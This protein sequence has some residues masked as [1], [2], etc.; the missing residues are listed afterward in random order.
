LHIGQLVFRNSVRAPLRTFMT[1]LTVAIML[2]AFVFP[3]T[4]V[5]EQDRYVEEAKNDRVL[6]LP[7]QGWTAVLPA[8]YTDEVRSTDGV[9]QVVGVRWAGF[10][11]PGKDD[12]FF[13]SNAVDAA[14]FV[15][16]HHE[17]SAPDADKRAFIADERSVLVS[18]DLA[19]ERGWKLGD[20]VILQSH[21]APGEWEVTVACVYE[22]AGG[23]W[24]KRSL[25]AHYGFFNRGLPTE[26]RDQLQF[27]VA[28][29]SEPSRAAAVARALDAYFD[30][31]SMPTLSMEDQAFAAA[32]IA[33]LSALLGALDLVSVLILFVVAAILFN[34]LSLG[35]RE[36]TRE[37][38]VLRA[39][40]FGPGQLCA[41]VL[42]EA[43]LLGLASAVLGLGLSYALLEGLVGPFLQESLQ[44]PEL[45]VPPAVA[46]M[47]FGAGLC[48]ALAAAIVP[49]I[50]VARLEVRDALGRV[51]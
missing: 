32:N 1:V 16:M 40:G 30:A 4:L 43:A 37:L 45:E 46:V 36:R 47:G 13:A 29:V 44:F 6:M 38:G 42:A 34:T 12:L 3:R 14:P 27:I 25:W 9:A 22:A 10:K 23:S 15:A 41:L 11:L 48:L 24:A 2:A 20:R 31:E 18:R 39:I 21:E 8:R 50:R 33:R 19:R 35:V 17:I 7:T 28:Q 51:A 26:K 5:V 49:S